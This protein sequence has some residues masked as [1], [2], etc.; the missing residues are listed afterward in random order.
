MS[1]SYKAKKRRAI[2]IEELDRPLPEVAP[3]EE[4]HRI[5]PPGLEPFTH[6]SYE[7]NPV[8]GLILL[9][10]PTTSHRFDLL[11]YKLNQYCPGS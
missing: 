11:N 8:T 7:W 6:E 4:D 3:P 2:R 9:L 1:E 5:G 10:V